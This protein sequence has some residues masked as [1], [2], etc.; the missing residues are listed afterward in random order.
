MIAGAH[1]LKNLMSIQKEFHDT[2]NPLQEV[3]ASQTTNQNNFDNYISKLQG[4]EI[5]KL[6]PQGENVPE[7][8]ELSEDKVLTS[9]NE[10]KVD[11]E[12]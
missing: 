7:K 8:I 4:E 1:C 6:Y 11:E 3:P 12:R 5:A 9:I 10:E 2:Y